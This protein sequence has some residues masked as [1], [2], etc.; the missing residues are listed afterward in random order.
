ML[1]YLYIRT[2]LFIQILPPVRTDHVPTSEE[3][4]SSSSSLDEESSPTTGRTSG[5]ATYSAG[6]AHHHHHKSSN[7]STSGS[8]NSGGGAGQIIP[9]VR[10][11]SGY[12]SH[13]EETSFTATLPKFSDRDDQLL[14]GN[15]DVPGAKGLSMKLNPGKHEKQRQSRS[16]N[17]GGFHIDV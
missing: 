11:S 7:K 5:R 16:K 8:S 13:T 14:H 10:S 1:K 2:Y 4:E 3:M 9:R 17:K 12:S 6:R 15:D